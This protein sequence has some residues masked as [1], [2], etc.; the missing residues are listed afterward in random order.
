MSVKKTAAE[1]AE[2]A[3]AVEKVAAEKKAGR[4]CAWRNT[5]RTAATNEATLNLSLSVATILFYRSIGINK[6]QHDECQIKD[7]NDGGLSSQETIRIT[8]HCTTCQGTQQ[9][10]ES[11]SKHLTERIKK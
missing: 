2:K 5:T 8:V 11:R 3:A 1:K 6:S 4:L 9:T 7:C 10:R